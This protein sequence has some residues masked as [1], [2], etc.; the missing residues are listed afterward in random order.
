M[1]EKTKK[2]LTESARFFMN[3]M[4]GTDSEDEF[5]ECL[6]KAGIEAKKGEGKD[7][8]MT[9]WVFSDGTKL[10]LDSECWWIQ[11]RL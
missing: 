3:N 11:N 7:A 5:I 6:E 4:P 9:V 10:K 2:K 1:S 8:G